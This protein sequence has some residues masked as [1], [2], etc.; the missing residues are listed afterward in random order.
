MAHESYG[1]RSVSWRDHLAQEAMKVTLP[2][3]KGLTSQE[4]A[5]ACYNIA[6][7]MIREGSKIPNLEE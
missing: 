7:A 6:D 2:Y 5:R 4:V 3:A 1:V